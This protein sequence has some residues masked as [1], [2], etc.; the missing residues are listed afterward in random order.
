MKRLTISMMVFMGTLALGIAGLPDAASALPD[1][2]IVEQDIRY[3]R[4]EIQL[5]RGQ[6]IRVFNKD[7]WFH[8]TQ[9]NKINE[10]G[11]EH[12]A[13]FGPRVEL[14]N[15]NWETSLKEVGHYKLRC[16]I[17]DGMQANVHVR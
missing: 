16:M 8:M 11:I 9:I 5:E 1:V 2:E 15:T 6:T 3:D 14:P 10:H 17:H 13:V 7:P 12:A 4:D